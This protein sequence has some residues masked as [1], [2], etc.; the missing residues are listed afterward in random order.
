MRRTARLAA[1]RLFPHPWQRLLR[2]RAAAAVSAVSAGAYLATGCALLRWTAVQRLHA[3][4]CKVLMIAA[5]NDFTPLAEKR[6]LASRLGA[7][8]VVVRG[9]RHGTPFD[10]VRATNACLLAL[11]TDQPLPPEER[12]MRDEAERWHELP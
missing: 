2:E 6:A 12:R 5:E 7:D 3:L 11:L 1:R 4:R 10:A 8:L 9:S